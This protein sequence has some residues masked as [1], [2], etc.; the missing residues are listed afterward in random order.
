MVTRSQHNI[1]QPKI[2]TDGTIL[3]PLPHALNTSLTAHDTKP[4]CFTSASKHQEWH[5]AMAK[6][7][8][9]LI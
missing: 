2:P 6:V 4:T 9:T 3:Y 7:F 1:H 8:N 5:S